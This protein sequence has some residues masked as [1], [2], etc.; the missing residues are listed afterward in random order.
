MNATPRRTSGA[1]IPIALLAMLLL[2]PLSFGPACWVATRMS[3]V[4]GDRFNQIYFPI[5]WT[6]N[7]S[8]DAVQQVIWTYASLGEGDLQMMIIARSEIY[9]FS[10]PSD[11]YF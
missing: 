6:Y 8:P 5:I 3:S 10:P 11:P 7:N 1:W 4:N 2:Y 9:F